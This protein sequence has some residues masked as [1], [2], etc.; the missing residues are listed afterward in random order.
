[1]GYSLDWGW[2]VGAGGRTVDEGFLAEDFLQ[3]DGDGGFAALVEGEGHAGACA[4]AGKLSRV[5]LAHGL[6]L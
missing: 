2:G 4:L 5:L 1:M 6:V 3:L